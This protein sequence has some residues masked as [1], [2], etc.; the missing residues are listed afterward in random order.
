[1][2][3]EELGRWHGRVTMERLKKELEKREFRAVICDSND[4]AR[5]FMSAE[6]PDGCSVGLGGSV[7]LR[8]IGIDR[9]LRER[10]IALFDHWA[11][12]STREERDGIRRKQLGADIFLTGC[13]AL[14]MDGR[15]VNIDG[16]GN[17]VAA[18]SF[19]PRKVI[20][21]AGINKVAPD[22]DGALWRI[23]NVAAPMNSRRLGHD[24]PCASTGYCVDCRS[25]KTTCRITTI[26]EY[27]PMLT[28]YIVLLLPYEAGL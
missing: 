27:R 5:E 9:R 1:M 17:R 18:M 6:I 15:L 16:A 19:G 28:E 13:N 23:R 3:Y 14:T 26:I 4:E 24:S 25:G 11:D 10:G 21:A 12:G 22:L 20:A 7:T 8:Q 2:N